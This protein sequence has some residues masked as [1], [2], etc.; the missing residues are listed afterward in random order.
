MNKKFYPGR[1][2]YQENKVIKKT[3]DFLKLRTLYESGQLI[4]PIYQGALE[5]DRIIGMIQSYLKNPEFFQYKNTIVVGEINNKFYIIDGQHRVEMAIILCKEYHKYRE[6][7]IIAYYKLKNQTEALKLFNEINIDSKKNQNYI[8]L[9]TFN[10]L[11]INEFRIL[12]KNTYKSHF[13][14]KKS[15][16]GRVKCIE[17]FVDE[18]HS[19][20]FF[21]N[22][23]SSVAFERLLKLN[24]EFYNS[25]YDVIFINNSYV[26]LLYKNEINHIS[27]KIVFTIKNNNFIKFVKDQ[28]IKP[29]HIWKKGKKRITARIKKLVWNKEFRDKDVGKCPISFCNNKITCNKFKS[30]YIGLFHAGHITSEFNG[31]KVEVNNLRPICSSCN[32][33]MGTNNWQ[34]YDITEF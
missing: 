15:E 12:L 21:K 7:M 3:I 18:L 26:S 28:D 16:K 32:S 9:N 24:N 19:I 2:L 5:K 11:V 27:N 30:N 8:N 1:L 10:Q 20:N 4:K 33:S 17:E 25:L 29:N 6:Q 22:K 13:S 23:S 34:E 14:K 31:G